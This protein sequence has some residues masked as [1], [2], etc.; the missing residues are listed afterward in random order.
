MKTFIL[1]F[2]I[3][4]SLTNIIA[5]TES[6]YGSKEY[7]DDIK[8]Y[9][10]TLVNKANKLKLEILSEQNSLSNFQKNIKADFTADTFYIEKVFIYSSGGTGSSNAIA[11]CNYILLNEYDKLLNKYYK[12]L[13]D[14][15]NKDSKDMLKNSQRNWLEYRNSERKFNDNLY[16]DCD[17][18]LMQYIW[19]SERAVEITKAR[20]NEIL[21]YLLRDGFN[22]QS[23]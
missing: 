9:K 7:Y 23:E 5:Q 17:Q 8:K 6:V 19:I 1:I 4:F 16:F 2:C 20:V 10:K 22:S 21:E 12:I 3:T 14:S 15:L 18:G 13:M 11:D